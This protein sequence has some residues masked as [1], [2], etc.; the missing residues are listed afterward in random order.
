MI[1]DRAAAGSLPCA[2]S[3]A[4][5]GE[6]RPGS[7]T[8]S[9]HRENK[10]QFRRRP[11]SR[12]WSRCCHRRGHAQLGTR[13][14]DRCRHRRGSRSGLAPKKSWDGAMRPVA[15]A[16]GGFRSGSL[17]RRASSP[18]GRA[19]LGAHN[20]AQAG[21]N[22]GIAYGTIQQIQTPGP[23][24][25]DRGGHR[26]PGRSPLRSHGCLAGRWIFRRR[27]G[28]F[29]V[30]PQ[31]MSQVRG[32]R[33][34]GGREVEAM[35]ARGEDGYASLAKK[36]LRRFCRSHWCSGRH[37]R[38]FGHKVRGCNHRGDMCWTTCWLPDRGHPWFRRGMK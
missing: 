26:S 21:E 5:P 23:Q 16:R 11:R 37:R 9:I 35:I 1:P 28:R 20:P 27:C 36:T 22:E 15:E 6:A 19:S 18:V 31:G 4:S 38:V 12:S 24:H 29:V 3:R 8:R 10:T 34:F 25:R 13:S 30:W 14:R 7:E 2:W 32:Q 17:R 33:G